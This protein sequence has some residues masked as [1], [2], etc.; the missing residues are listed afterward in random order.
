MIALSR[1]GFLKLSAGIGI[2]LGLQR[3]SW[4]EGQGGTPAALP[5]YR[6]WED[7]YRQRWQWD[8]VARGTHTNA[9]C[10]AACSWNLYVRDGI[11]WREEQSAP[12]TASNA[13]VP[14]FN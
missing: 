10:V 7:V 8:K 13:S 4:A 2:T 14:D 6:G 3:L 1:R 12:Y 11:V 5:E 9:N